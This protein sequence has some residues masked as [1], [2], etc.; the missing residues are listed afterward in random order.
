MPFYGKRQ[1]PTVTCVNSLK[2][3]LSEGNGCY[4]I[5]IAKCLKRMLSDKELSRIIEH[6]K[7]EQLPFNKLSDDYILIAAPDKTHKKK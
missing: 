4:V 7:C 2:K 3:I 5:I 1:V 6:C